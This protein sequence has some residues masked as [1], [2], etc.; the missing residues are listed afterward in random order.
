MILIVMNVVMVMLETVV[1]YRDLY[2]SYF[3][4][5]DVVSVAIFTVEYLLRLWSIAEDPKY[6]GILKGRFRFALTPMALIDLLA[7]LPFYLP[8]IMDLDLRMIRALRL[9]RLFRV[10][11][12]GRYSHSLRVFG[13]VIR[14]KKEE[15]GIVLFMLLILLVIASSLMYFVEHDKQPEAFSSIPASMWWGV[16][17]LTTVGYGDVYPIT[18]I[19][20]FLGML[21]A[22]LGIGLFALPAAILSSGFVVTVQEREG[23]MCPHCGEII[24]EPQKTRQGDPEPHEE[25]RG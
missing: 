12:F 10:L 3:H 15:M 14:A 21:I 2:A 19:G 24:T 20:R 11:K 23:R 6:K 1:S 8:M 22:V 4:I 7:I 13:S 18:S 16:M 5:F 9:I 25:E 17:T